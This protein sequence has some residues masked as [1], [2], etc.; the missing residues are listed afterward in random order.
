M[1]LGAGQASPKPSA[2]SACPSRKFSFPRETDTQNYAV[3][4]WRVFPG[5]HSHLPPGAGGKHGARDRYRANRSAPLT[6]FFRV[7]DRFDLCRF[8]RDHRGARPALPKQLQEGSA[9]VTSTLEISRRQPGA[10]RKEFSLREPAVIAGG[11]RFPPCVTDLDVAL[12]FYGGR[13]RCQPGASFHMPVGRCH[14][15]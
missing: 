6:C 9:Q 15:S 12:V 10:S 5:G 14:A 1:F 13:N 3:D 2:P 11:G 4:V 8:M 7:N